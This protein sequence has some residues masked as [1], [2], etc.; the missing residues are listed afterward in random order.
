MRSPSRPSAPSSRL[1]K[2]TA[3]RFISRHLTL[4]LVLSILGAA[5]VL[6]SV[7]AGSSTESRKSAAGAATRA[8]QRQGVKSSADQS[9]ERLAAEVF[10]NPAAALMQT[11]NKGNGQIDPGG[12]Q[13]RSLQSN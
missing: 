10:A 3:F 1:Q 9:K 4:S 11:P 13:E 7:L 12:T 8:G 6:S 5:V 2:K